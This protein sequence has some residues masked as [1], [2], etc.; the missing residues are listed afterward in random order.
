MEK[1]VFFRAF[2]E[3]DIDAI[4]R[5]KIQII[6]HDFAPL[7]LLFNPEHSVKCRLYISQKPDLL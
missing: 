2:E 7:Y 3:E 1:T 4:Y 5:W 6:F